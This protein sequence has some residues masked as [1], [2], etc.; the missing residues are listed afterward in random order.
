MQITETFQTFVLEHAEDDTSRLLL[1]AAQHKGIDIKLAVEQIL[2]RR[3]IKTKLP[4]WYSNS[5][6]FYPSTLAAEQCS[7]EQTASYKQRLIKPEDSLCDLT[8]GL[9]V[10]TYFFS[11]IVQHVT[12]VEQDEKYC[13]AARHNMKTLG[14]SN[15]NIINS[16]A[17][18]IVAEDEKQVS[19]VNTFYIDPARRGTGNKRMFAIC[20]CTPDITEMWPIMRRRQCKI[21]VKL[22]P[23]LD[24]SQ[25]LSQLTGVNEVHVV[26]VR[27][28]CK[29]LLIVADA[30][31]PTDEQTIET[32]VFCTN[33]TSS[34]TEQTFKFHLSEEHSASINFAQK[35]SKYLYEPNS[36]ILKA[37]AYKS[38]AKSFRIEKLQVS[39]HL[40]TSDSLTPSFPGRIF[41]ITEIIPFG[42]RTCKGLSVRIAQANISTR[43]FPLSADEL[44]K[45]TRISDGGETYIFATT[46]SDN[47]KVLMICRKASL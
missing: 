8:G 37:G 39:S 31:P 32:E 14:A 23:M 18:K 36:S 9:G 27:N 10:D 16:D 5:R 24:I 26:S 33:Y 3:Q 42:S 29:E 44:R 41:E 17:A 13:N 7:S 35:A 4:S 22:S 40:Y 30:T 47:K 46:L 1:N 19:G 38:I 6:I 15:I 21:I 45:R 11:Q 25:V 20:D 43:N 34:G 12:Y 28:D 2:A